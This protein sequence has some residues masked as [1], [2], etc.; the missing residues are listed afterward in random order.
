MAP[1]RPQH[2]QRKALLHVTRSRLEASRRA[3]GCCQRLRC[4]ELCALR[5]LRAVGLQAVVRILGGTP[6]RARRGL[7]DGEVL[8]HRLAPLVRAAVEH[9]EIAVVR[10]EILDSWDFHEFDFGP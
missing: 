9:P 1:S 2:K 10:A 4:K 7:L 8:L 6:G 3:L 5:G